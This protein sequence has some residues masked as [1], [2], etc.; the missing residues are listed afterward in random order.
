MTSLAL[1]KPVNWSYS[2]GTV[3]I[4]DVTCQVQP[5]VTPPDLSHLSPICPNRGNSPHPRSLQKLPLQVFALFS[6]SLV[7]LSK[8]CSKSHFHMALAGSTTAPCS[9]HTV[10]GIVFF[11]IRFLCKAQD[12]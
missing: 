5:N 6:F 7:P 12:F 10:L 9:I 3:S 11:I 8:H 4:S 2:A 1:L